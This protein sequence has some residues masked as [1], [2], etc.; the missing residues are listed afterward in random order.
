M[1]APDV[2]T[3][4]VGVDGSEP[5]LRAFEWALEEAKRSGRALDIVHVWHS[6]DRE[7]RRAT[8]PPAGLGPRDAGFNMLRRMVNKAHYY[9]VQATFHL[10]EGEVPLALIEAADN[11]ALLVVGTHDR[12]P[13]AAEMLGSVSQ[14]CI[15]EARCPV[16]V[17]PAAGAG[18]RASSM[19][20]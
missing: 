5:S 1:Q 9:G 6:G 13:L 17:V 16:V 12:T 15:Q 3:I 20:S 2:D 19:A 14:T 7:D 4:T 18:H 11:A 10:V 8:K